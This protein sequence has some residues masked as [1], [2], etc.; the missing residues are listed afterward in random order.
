[1]ETIYYFCLWFLVTTLFAYYSDNDK[2]QTIWRYVFTFLIAIVFY[3]FI[4][5][6][7]K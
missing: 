3:Y 4:Y 2:K 1:M 6:Y 5:V 7:K